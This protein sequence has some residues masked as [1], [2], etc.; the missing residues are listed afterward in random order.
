V[1][2]SNWVRT[3]KLNFRASRLQYLAQ[4]T[5]QIL[6]PLWL[7]VA[8]AAYGFRSPWSSELLPELGSLIELALGEGSIRAVKEAGGG[9][10]FDGDELDRPL[11]FSFTKLNEV[12]D[13]LGVFLRSLF[14]FARRVLLSVGPGMRSDRHGF[15]ADFD[16]WEAVPRRTSSTGRKGDSSTRLH[17]SLP[18]ASARV[19]LEWIAPLKA[20]IRGRMEGDAVLRQQAPV[21]DQALAGLLHTIVLSTQLAGSLSEDVISA[22]ADVAGD[23]T[24]ASPIFSAIST[25]HASMES[26]GLLSLWYVSQDW[27]EPLQI[28]RVL[29]KFVW[30]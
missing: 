2:A 9:L 27:R 4:R 30:L 3:T 16:I 10:G 5:S 22:V 1:I 19:C 17:S 13:N 26:A 29:I 24:L 21:Y 18:A 8:E 11:S 23:S 12:G 7:G 6:L 20:E 15:N 25:Y 28:A 14:G